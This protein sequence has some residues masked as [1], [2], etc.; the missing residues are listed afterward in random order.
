[1]TDSGAISEELQ[2]KIEGF[3]FAK[4]EAPDLVSGLTREQF[5]WR[6][7]DRSWSVGECIDHL[8]QTGIHLVPAMKAEIDAGRSAGKTATGLF[9]YS[10]LGT[11]FS[12]AAG[13]PTDPNKGKLKAQSC[14]CPDRI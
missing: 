8:Y 10:W 4:T 1:M 6:I 9:K 2:T 3:E 12:K 11:T 14:M 5:N 13:V 7:D